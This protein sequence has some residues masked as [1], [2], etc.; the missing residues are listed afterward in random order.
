VDKHATILILGTMPSTT[1]LQ[2]AQYYAHPDN[3]FWDILF[4]VCIPEWKAEEVV[5]VPYSQKVALAQQH[6][7]AIWDV[8][9]YCDRK[10]NLDRDIRNQIHNDFKGFFTTYN[11]IKAV[12]FNGQKPEKFFSDFSN[13]PEIFEGR[14]FFQ[15]QSTSPSN[16]ANAFYKLKDWTC[17]RAY[18]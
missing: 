6:K 10:G 11:Q 4:R 9:Q 5:N 15:L 12:F 1:S 13:I 18:I 3:I 2:H 8:L 16:S 14:E 7:I 17:I